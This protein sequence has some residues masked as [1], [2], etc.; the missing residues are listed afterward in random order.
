MFLYTRINK[1]GLCLTLGIL[2]SLI[3]IINFWG[4]SVMIALGAVIAE[5]LWRKLDRN[6]FSTML[7]CFTTQIFAW[8]LGMLLPLTLMTQIYINNFQGYEEVYRGMADMIMGPMMLVYIATTI[9]GCVLGALV[10][11]Q[12][13]KKHFV[14]AGIV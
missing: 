14:K 13:L 8:F 10:G 6:K 2:L 5:V 12:I 11:K 9:V 3:N 4:T 1:K 7:I